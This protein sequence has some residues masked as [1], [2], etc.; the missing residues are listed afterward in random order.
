MNQ[1]IIT[2]CLSIYIN[3]NFIECFFEVIPC[4]SPREILLNFVTVFK[5]LTVLFIVSLINFSW[6]KGCF[7]FP[8]GCFASLDYRKKIMDCINISMLVQVSLFIQ[9][10]TVQP[11]SIECHQIVTHLIFN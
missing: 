1:M 10:T 7:W 3:S 6:R 5:F 8:N 9:Y 11:F 4:G 2:N